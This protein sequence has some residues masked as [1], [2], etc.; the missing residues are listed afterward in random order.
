MKKTN[1]N[2][3]QSASQKEALSNDF[4]EQESEMTASAMPPAF[5]LDASPD[6]IE[7][8]RLLDE[9]EDLGVPIEDIQRLNTSISKEGQRAATDSILDAFYIKNNWLLAENA[10]PL[11]MH[12][13]LTYFTLSGKHKGHVELAK[14][15]GQYGLRA[16]VPYEG[17]GGNMIIDPNET[18]TV[19]GRGGDTSAHP[20]GFGGAM[21]EPIGTNYVRYQ[22]NFMVGK[23]KGGGNVLDVAD[24]DWTWPLNNA[25]LQASIDRG[26]K[27]RFISDPTL[28]TTLFRRGGSIDDGLTVTGQELGVLMNR[29]FAPDLSSGIVKDMASIEN[30][31]EDWFDVMD[32]IERNGDLEN[33]DTEAYEVFFSQSLS[34]SRSPKKERSQSSEILAVQTNFF[35][36]NSSPIG[37]VS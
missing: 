13:K 16:L 31:P 20:E 12:E 15:Q 1:E 17:F 33:I 24:R 14:H 25:W 2:R 21:N 9:I 30:A 3:Q 28:P 4:S 32:Q 26:D 37:K 18:T 11:A 36:N 35:G 19:L 27:M 6:A 5:A 7:N 23:N 29:G 8:K 34:P 22:P 10:S